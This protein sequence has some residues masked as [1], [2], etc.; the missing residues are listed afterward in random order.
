MKPS[1]LLELAMNDLEKCEADPRYEI[2]MESWHDPNGE[3]CKVC[4]A[5]AV[6]AQTCGLPINMVSSG[7]AKD[8]G[9]DWEKGTDA[10]NAF[11]M[12]KINLALRYIGYGGDWT[13]RDIVSY[14]DDKDKFKKQMRQLVKD[15]KEA[16]L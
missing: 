8:V 1:E 6:M 16:E 5:G 14:H 3:I 13:D 2:S 9:E 15:L 11:R 7:L 12:G 10:L 4:L